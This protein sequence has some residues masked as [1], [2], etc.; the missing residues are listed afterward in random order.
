MAILVAP[1]LRQPRL[2]LTSLLLGVARAEPLADRSPGQP[3]VVQSGSVSGS[4]PRA[5]CAPSARLRACRDPWRAVLQGDRPVV[6]PRRMRLGRPA[7][8]LYLRSQLWLGLEGG[9]S[10]PTP[11]ASCAAWSR[12]AS[13]SR[14]SPQTASPASPP[15]PTSSHAGNVV[16]RPAGRSS[17]TWPTTCLLLAALHLAR[18]FAAPP[19]RTQSSFRVNG[20]SERSDTH[21]QAFRRSDASVQRLATAQR[22]L[23]GP[24]LQGSERS[25]AAQTA[26]EFAAAQRTPLGF[27][28]SQ[29]SERSEAGALALYQRHTALNVSGALLSRVL[30][31]PLVLEFNSSEVWEGPL[32]GRVAAGAR[33]GDCGT[34][35]PAG[36]RSRGGGLTGT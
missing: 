13:P 32:L 1:D 21:T 35:Q 8:V 20:T 33:G 15:P 29:R 17:R 30:R 34:D 12:L 5:H 27:A 24:E 16:R 22:P 36:G 26:P 9:G 14:S 18:R 7:R 31:V 6:K 19:G 23:P 2:R 11:P 4:E 3:R 28:E 25:E 10:S